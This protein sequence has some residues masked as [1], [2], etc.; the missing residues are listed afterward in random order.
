MVNRDFR[1]CGKVLWLL[2][3]CLVLSLVLI[4]AVPAQAAPR[5]NGWVGSWETS[6]VQLDRSQIL[7]AEAGAD[8]TIRQVVRVGLGGKRIRIRLS[9][10]FGTSPLVIAGANLAPSVDNATARIDLTG[11]RTIRFAG[12]TGVSIAP[13]AAVLS[14][15]V[16]VTV[17][18]GADLAVSLHLTSVP[19]GQTGHGGSRATSWIAHGDRIG[20]ADL[21][22]AAP[23]VHWYF[24]SGI[25]VQSPGTRAIVVMGDSIT[26][27]YG[28]QPDSNTR[29]TDFLQARFRRDPALARVA[30]LNAGIGG[31]AIRGGGLGPKPASRLSRELFEVPGVS[32]FVIFA[33]VNDLR[34]SGKGPATAGQGA[35]IVGEIIEELRG[36]IARVRAKGIRAIGVTVL[37]YAR[38]MGAA[39]IPFDDRDR[40][41]LNDWITAPGNFDAV[42]DLAGPMADPAAPERL[43]GEYDNDGLHPSIAGY[44]AMAEAVPLDLFRD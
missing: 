16:S 35:Q 14:D 29:F 10:L 9:N 8:A 37:P 6:L 42:I 28:V 2:T 1:P 39:A 24:L 43:R 44:R 5:P 41:A 12:R 38:S 18:D 31:N 40:L 4:P 33:G 7:P 11:L 22:D 23:A 3:L 15:P 36:I 34:G 25:D 19:A 26:D 27:G 30:V 13:G 21:S 20:E 17:A 32:H